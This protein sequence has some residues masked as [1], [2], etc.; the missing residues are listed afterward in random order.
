[1]CAA[2]PIRKGG[3]GALFFL[4]TLA[5]WLL[6]RR[7]RGLAT[8][9][10]VAAAVAIA[11][12]GSAS[13][14]AVHLDQYRSAETPTDGF[15]MSRP[16]D[17]GHL[18]LGAQLQLDYGFNPLVYELRQGE[19]DSESSSTVE[20]QLAAQLG[21]SFGLFDR[22]VVFAGLP[23]NLVMEGETPAGAFGPDGAGSVTL[24]WGRAY[25][26]SVKP[27]TWSHSRASSARPSR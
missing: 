19:A 27:T 10:A 20:H 11:G 6:W 5:G 26:S 15:A 25:G 17:L 8:V 2:S 7:R 14:Q 1:M 9:G 21:V 23:V 16:N 12:P 3:T 22:I 13:A 4:V 18:Q 24:G